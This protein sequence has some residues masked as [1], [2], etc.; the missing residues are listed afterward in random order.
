MFS[1]PTRFST[2]TRTS[3]RNTSF[4]VWAS[5]MAMI[6]RTVIPGVFRSTSRKEMPAWGLPS[7]LVRTSRNSHSAQ[8]ASEVQI[9]WPLTT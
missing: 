3:S 5:S 4:R 6:G 9:F 7:V 8:W 2:G 1:W